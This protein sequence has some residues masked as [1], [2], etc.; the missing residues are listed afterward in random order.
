M[1]V[2][3]HALVLLCVLVL[4]P[5]QAFID[6]PWITPE[7][8][9]AN[10]TVYVNLRFGICDA[11]LDD[12][13]EP[14][15][16]QQG[17]NIRILFSSVHH[18]DPILCFYPELMAAWPVG[19]FPPGTYTLQ[20]DRW[21]QNGLEGD[22]TTETLG[23]LP[24]TVAGVIGPPTSVPT[25]GTL[26][27]FALAALL[28][29]LAIARLRGMHGMLIAA[30]M[31]SAVPMARA[32]DALPHSPELPPNHSIELLLRLAPGAPSAED[33]VRYAATPD[34]APP[35]NAFAAIP[36]EGIVYVMPIRAEGDF[37]AWLDANPDSPR[38]R[39]ERYVLVHYAEPIDLRR[40]LEV[41][42]ADPYVEAAQEPM[43]LRFNAAELVDFGVDGPEGD[44]Q[45]GRDALNIDAAWAVTGG[46]YALVQ[47]IDSGLSTQHPQLRQ[48]D[49]SGN[50]VGGNFVPVASI[51][52]GGSLLAAPNTVPPDACVDERE[53][54]HLPSCT[55][56]G[57]VVN[58][59]PPCRADGPA[60]VSPDYA[61]GHGTHTSG[62]LAANGAA[63]TIGGTCKACGVA[64][65]KTLYTRCVAG[66][67]TQIYDP[68]ANASSLGYSGD[69][70]TQ[71]ASLSADIQRFDHL[72]P[73]NL[74]TRIQ[75]G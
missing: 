55:D 71:V 14:E 12:F 17:S 62:L 18:T 72:E 40:A 10:E 60:M 67:V 6:P 68:D 57:I 28:A 20:V 8:P 64:L 36:P 53:P 56:D 35:L 22:I 69:I 65:W 9:Q 24:F 51:D 37:R 47:V 45:Y 44:G 26:L 13:K 58:L 4:Q 33:L 75:K 38:A 73:Y 2:L 74:T 31:L 48:F 39:L 46:G 5:A 27:P 21:Y 1:K 70:G 15:I 3:T 30:M 34:G 49:A 11:I 50:Y 23:V 63:G 54:M 32:A 16:S 42:R 7:S 19:T 43:A 29:L 52:I 59:P 41:L 25:L 66:N 61:I